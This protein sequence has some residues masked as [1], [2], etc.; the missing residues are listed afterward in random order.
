MP[1]LNPTVCLDNGLMLLMLMLVI[2]SCCEECGRLGM[3]S[4]AESQ[5]GGVFFPQKFLRGA[6][7]APDSLPPFA[8]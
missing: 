3:L 7:D 6:H 1:G 2:L 8:C 5:R 4:Q